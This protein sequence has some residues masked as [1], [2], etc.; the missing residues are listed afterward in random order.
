MVERI[1]S[2][3][4]KS[5]I[6]RAQAGASSRR[7][8]SSLAVVCT[9]SSVKSCSDRHAAHRLGKQSHSQIIFPSHLPKSSSQDIF[10]SHRLPADQGSSLYFPSSIWTRIRE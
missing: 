3:G 1:R 2:D 5:S 9:L 4:G 10:P 8:L 7:L 6:P